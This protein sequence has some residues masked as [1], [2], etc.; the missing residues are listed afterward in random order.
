MIKLKNPL[1]KKRENLM[2]WKVFLTALGIGI[3]MILPFII[4]DGGYFFYYG[5]YNVQ[6]VPFWQYCAEQ[7]KSGNFFWSWETDLGSDFIS[8]Y[9]FY[10]IGSPFFWLAMI[11]PS[12]WMPALMGPLMMLKMAVA[13]VGAFLYM[14]RY[15]KD[16]DYAMIG[17]LL[18]A[19]SSYTIY[20]IFFNHFIDVVAV[21]P[22]MLLAF[23]MLFEDN[24]WGW[25]ALFTAVNLLT[26][27]FFFVGEVVFFIL[28]Y[29]IRVTCPDDWKFN[30]KKL[31]HGILEALVGVAIAAF[32][33]LPSFLEL[34]SNPRLD[35]VFN[36]WGF[37]IYGETRR[38]MG[39]LHALLFPPE[40][41]HFTYFIENSNTRWQSVAAWLPL[42]AL[43]MVIAFLAAKKSKG[44]WQKRVLI[45]FGVALLMPGVGSIF[46]LMK[47]VYYS[48]W[49]YMAV[50]VMA[51]VTVKVLEN[52]EEYDL[53]LGMKW[54]AIFTLLLLIPI[55]F[56]PVVSG[57]NTISQIGLYVKNWGAPIMF[58]IS[59]CITVACMVILYLLYDRL[60][61][62]GKVAVFKKYV[63][64]SLVLVIC[65]YSLFILTAGK[66]SSE[67]SQVM[68]DNSLN[69]ANLEIPGAP[70]D[71][72]Y[73]IDVLDGLDNQGLYWRK[74]SINFFHSVVS[75][76]IM[77]FYEFIG[78]E[79]NVASRP[80]ASL[81][82]LRSVTSVKYIFEKETKTSYQSLYNTSYL[83]NMNGYDVYVN[84]NY[85]PFGFTYNDY[86]LEYDAKKVDSSKIS[87]LMVYALVLDDETAAKYSYLFDSQI[88]YPSEELNL[89]SAG[90]NTAVEERKAETAYNYNRTNKGYSVDI[91]LTKDNLVFFSVPYESGWSCTVNGES[92]TVEK[93]NAG[94]TAVL[95]NTGH[96]HIEFTYETPGLKKGVMISA[97]GLVLLAG[98]FVVGAVVK[99]RRP[100]EAELITE[101]AFTPENA[102]MPELTGEIAVPESANP[103]P[104]ATEPTVSQVITQEQV[105]AQQPEAPVQEE[106]IAQ[107]EPKQN[108]E[109][110][111]EQK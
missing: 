69:A 85:I 94:L 25:F 18:Y 36:G 72:F 76:S 58:A 42:F 97:V 88:Y 60:L 1:I 13:A 5:D 53:K 102:I 68:I 73:R 46:Y 32:M 41:P 95:A 59:A 101:P 21:F 26:N 52:Y 22:F 51:L 106:V 34:M 107:E 31:L 70:E 49:L 44:S 86:V 89:T 8:A 79:R 39:V 20:N 104:L 6:Q 109:D 16:P 12:S 17:A 4:K 14:R 75:P 99:K 30:F 38:Y 56:L 24:K 35:S 40:L 2:V 91:D 64:L 65:L 90:F 54:N 105:P 108:P 110:Q 93:A 28:Y 10:T 100:V 61:K 19:F 83:T 62:Q 47:A 67:G 11:F 50:M 15:I 92:V 77:E 48:R 71:E 82:G 98:L 37:Y 81:N 96:N 87:D 33:M 43:S 29:V 57:D 80:A 103:E 66:V 74:S 23:D 111:E 7:V 63:S 45:C 55:A 3:V 27:Y 78:E 9:S 84:N